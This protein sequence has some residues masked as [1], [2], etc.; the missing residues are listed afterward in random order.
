MRRHA[1]IVFVVPAL[2]FP[3]S[4]DQLFREIWPRHKEDKRGDLP[5]ELYM[6]ITKI[7]GAFSHKLS[8]IHTLLYIIHFLTLFN[9]I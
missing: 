8:I 5:W 2:V 6:G 1:A 4:M 9:L 7:D 3:F